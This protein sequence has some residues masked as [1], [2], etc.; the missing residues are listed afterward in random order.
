MQTRGYLFALVAALAVSIMQL[1]AM[2]QAGWIIWTKESKIVQSSI[3][4]GPLRTC[5]K[6]V[7]HFGAEG[8]QSTHELGTA[9]AVLAN[10]PAST[11]EVLAGI[12]ASAYPTF[13]GDLLSTLSDRVAHPLD[14]DDGWVCR[15][16]PQTDQD[17]NSDGDR[18]FCNAF[19]TAGYSLQ[20]SGVLLI[21][22]MISSL[23]TIFSTSAM[24]KVEGYR[25]VGGML[26]AAS[27]LGI[28][29]FAIVHD[30]YKNDWPYLFGASLSLGAAFWVQLVAWVVGVL[31][32]IGVLTVGFRAE[33]G[34]LT[35]S[36]PVNGYTRV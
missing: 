11:S 13:T 10:G 34:A 23:L 22:S 2:R 12:N 15:P 26:G 18:A 27:L 6:L 19:L 1:W 16:F 30:A 24:N 3:Q 31:S 36:A 29:A 7:V 17:C 8:T 33:R 20:F 28:V 5:S 4:Y 35:G 25:V 14:K 32:T 9:S 21:G